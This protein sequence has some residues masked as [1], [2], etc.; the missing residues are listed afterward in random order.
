VDLLLEDGEVGAKLARI[1]LDGGG[2]S[3][4][5]YGTADG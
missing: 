3:H 4:G 5:S 2:Y 1:E